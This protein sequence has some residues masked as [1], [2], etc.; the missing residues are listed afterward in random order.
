[1]NELQCKRIVKNLGKLITF[2][3]SCSP[4]LATVGKD[5]QFAFYT[6]NLHNHTVYISNEELYK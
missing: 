4:I 5:F 2:K 3:T 6:N 1:M